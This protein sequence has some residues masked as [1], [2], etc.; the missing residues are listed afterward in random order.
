MC[1]HLD[2][3]EDGRSVQYLSF[4]E[5]NARKIW[6]M[7]LSDNNASSAARL[8]HPIIF[9]NLP[10]LFKQPFITQLP[11]Y[12]IP[13][14]VHYAHSGPIRPMQTWLAL[15]PPLIECMS[16]PTDKHSFTQF[17]V[18]IHNW[19][20]W[21]GLCALRMIAAYSWWWHDIKSFPHYWPFWG[22]YA[23]HRRIFLTRGH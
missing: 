19:G 17:E 7:H 3:A 20:K 22:E 10:C 23:G 5:K 12:L 15:E 6:R 21:C 4:V 8:T 11:Y 1:P 2:V 18:I 13:I 9:P 16:T 14:I